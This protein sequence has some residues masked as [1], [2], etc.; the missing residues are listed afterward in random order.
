M[1]FP[2]LKLMRGF[3]RNWIGAIGCKNWLCWHSEE[4]THCVSAWI[5]RFG[6]LFVRFFKFLHDGTLTQGRA[7]KF[8]G[9]MSLDD[10]A[11]KKIVSLLMALY[12]KI[13][14]HL[15]ISIPG[16]CLF[17]I[18]ILLFSR[19]GTQSGFLHHFPLFQ[20]ILTTT[21]LLRLWQTQGHLVG[22]KVP[23]WKQP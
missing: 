9:M 13:I 11:G 20:L 16:I 7:F 18:Y 23:V 22:F 21:I 14:S 17:L 15:P 4:A 3:H 6:V 1:C 12:C 19:S 10:Q 2:T 5:S 8:K